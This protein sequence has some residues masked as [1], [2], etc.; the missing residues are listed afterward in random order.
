[1]IFRITSIAEQ[2]LGEALDYY[3]AI[4]HGLAV[5]FLREFEQVRDRILTFPE[6]GHPRGDY[7]ITIIRG[8]PYCVAYTVEEDAIIVEAVA[9]MHRSISYRKDV[10]KRI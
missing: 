8:Y 4:E 7:K 6:S 9:H 5:R 2:E 3:K 1:M 10:S